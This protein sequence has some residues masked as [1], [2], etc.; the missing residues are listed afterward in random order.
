[1]Y[2]P[3]LLRNL[4]LTDIDPRVFGIHAC[5]SGEIYPLHRIERHV[6]HFVTQGQ[7]IYAVNGREHK[8][9]PG[10]IFICQ[11]DDVTSYIADSNDPFTYIWVSF[12]CCETF[13]SLLTQEVFYAPWARSVFSKLMGCHDSAVPEWAVCR[14]LHDFFLQLSEQHASKPA[15]HNDYVNRAVDYIQS[16]YSAPIGI[17]ELSADLG[18][19]RSYF[20]RL[21]KEQTGLSPKAYLISCRMER[22]AALM[23]EQGLSQKE[24][25]QQVGYTDVV[26][27]SRIFR[28]TCGMPP[29]EYVRRHRGDPLRKTP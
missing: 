26:T 28:Q 18:L 10:D 19:S 4:G 20:C 12:H 13:S 27:F 6:L 16:N 24:A 25:A 11:K 14:Q 8:V 9:G 21:F 22:A 7:G 29:G 15:F 23:T 3:Y 2:R 1:M 17:A 5:K